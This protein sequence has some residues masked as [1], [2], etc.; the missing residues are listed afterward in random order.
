MTCSSTSLGFVGSK[1][2]C[3]SSHDKQELGSYKLLVLSSF[4]TACSHQSFSNNLATKGFKELCKSQSSLHACVRCPSLSGRA[5]G[6]PSTALKTTVTPRVVENPL[7]ISLLLVCHGN[8]CDWVWLVCILTSRLG[9]R[10]SG[11][12]TLIKQVRIISSV[13]FDSCER[14]QARAHICRD[15]LNAFKEALNVM[16]THRMQ[17]E[18]QRAKVSAKQCLY[19]YILTLASFQIAVDVIRQANDNHCSETFLLDWKVCK[20]MERVWKD[21]NFRQVLFENPQLP[22]HHTLLW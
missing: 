21:T 16:K 20:A 22:Y 4:K 6:N 3:R 10:G 2:S 12:S 7:E 9:N 19:A 1:I 14:Y 8:E 11:K 5:A 13:G 18:S 15:F 17:F